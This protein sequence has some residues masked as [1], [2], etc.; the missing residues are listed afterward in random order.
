MNTTQ[1]VPFSSYDRSK[2]KRA[3]DDDVGRVKVHVQLHRLPR[4]LDSQ[5]KMIID[6]SGKNS[7]KISG[8]VGFDD[9][10]IIGSSELF[11]KT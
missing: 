7:P 3:C 4:K 1:I 2:A 11:E 6:V 9:L 5:S 10:F 8:F